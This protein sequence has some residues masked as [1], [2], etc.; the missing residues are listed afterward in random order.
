MAFRPVAYTFP[1]TFWIVLTLALVEL[2][3]IVSSWRRGAYHDRFFAVALAVLLALS[4]MWIG[5][6]LVFLPGSRYP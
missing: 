5:F 2:A 3:A 1:K 6:W 4:T